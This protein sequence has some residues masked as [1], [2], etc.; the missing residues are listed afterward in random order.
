MRVP[1]RWLSEFVDFQ[2]SPDELTKLFISKG[3]EVES[4]VRVGEGL[5][6]VVV[7]EIVELSEKTLTVTNGSEMVVLSGET[8]R[9]VP[10]ERVVLA[11]KG[12]ALPNGQK[13]T[14]DA[15]LRE[16]D[17]GLE[18]SQGLVILPREWKPGAAILDYLDDYVLEIRPPS[19]RGDLLGMKGIARELAAYLEKPLK[20]PERKFKELESKIEDRASLEVVDGESCPRYVARLITDLKIAVSP[21]PMR[22]RLSACGARPV[23]NIVDITNYILFEQGQPLHAFDFDRIEGKKIVVRRAKSSEQLRTLDGELRKLTADMLVIADAKRPIALAGVMGGK[24]SEVSLSTRTVLLES[25]F[26]RPGITRRTALKLKLITEASRRFEMGVDIGAIDDVSRATTAYLAGYGNPLK[27]SLDAFQPQSDRTIE[28]SLDRA[29]QLLG[30]KID[31]AGMKRFLTHLGFELET[32]GKDFTVFVPSFRQDI[33][34]DAELVEELARLYGYER[35]PHPFVLHGSVPGGA[36]ALSQR[37]GQ[38]RELLVSYGFNEIKTLSF[39]PER[40][41]AQFGNYK[42]LRLQNPLSE[43]FAVMR[44]NLIFGALEV[45]ALNYRRGNAD[46]RLFEIGKVFSPGKPPKENLSLA[47]VAVGQA[48]PHFWQERP[49]P[50]SFFDVKGVVEMCLGHL[51]LEEVFFRNWDGDGV[52]HRGAKICCGSETL[53]ALGEV[54][55]PLLAEFDLGQQVYVFELDLGRLFDFAPKYKVY[56]PLPKFPPVMRDL[57]LVASEEIEAA[58][59]EK[60]IKK[61]VGALLERMRI[62][63]YFSGKS[64]PPGKKSIGVRLV[65]RSEE[66]T[67]ESKEVERIMSR[68]VSRLEEQ[69]GVELRKKGG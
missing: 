58:Q 12:T 13:L 37:F 44:P 17:L 59:L 11:R 1:I 9:P 32:S 35:I 8:A 26:F 66:R 20:L 25:A 47:G 21:F 45:A 52:I 30:V 63:D 67:L 27:G 4:L 5:D 40:L 53:G 19:N 65:I 55:K 54:A 57:S 41:C 69:L 51:G 18:D 36:H 50:A 22:W 62:F 64:L 31:A 46:L 39:L 42:P 14:H 60:V 29:N 48:L 68:V 3:L 6:G 2:L 43:R 28:L 61:A 23:N 10:G 38:I 33:T 15:L 7:G 34:R 56:T 16:S 24:E 49:R